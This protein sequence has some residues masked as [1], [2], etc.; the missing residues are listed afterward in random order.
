MIFLI[1]K[2]TI[3]N[4]LTRDSS[5]SINHT[6]HT[7]GIRNPISEHSRFSWNNNNNNIM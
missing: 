2:T 7:S 1:V 6:K 4:K 3:T 5:T